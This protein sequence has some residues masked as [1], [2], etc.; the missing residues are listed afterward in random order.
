[1]HQAVAAEA[2]TAQPSAVRVHAAGKIFDNGGAAALDHVDL[3]IPAGSITV[4]LGPS[5]C[6]KTTLLRC[7]TGLETLSSGRIEI[8]DV[9]VSAVAAEDRGVAMVFQNYALYPN[10]TVLGN[11]EFPLKMR[12]VS[13]DIRRERALW[14]AKLMRLDELLERRPKELSGGQRQRVGIGRAL[15]RDPAVLVM[16]EPFSNL[17]AALRGTMRTELSALQRRLGMTVVFVTHD[18]VEALALADQLVVMRSGKVE[19]VGDPEDVYRRPATTFVAT[20]LGGMNLFASVGPLED[21]SR[22]HAAEIGFRPD[23]LRLGTGAPGDISLRG[24]VTAAELHGRDR[25]VDLDIAGQAARM[26]VSADVRPEG[27]LDLYIRREN[28]HHFAAD[29]N[30]LP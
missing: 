14:A 6:G 1:M 30:R 10:K 29:G 18:Q 28:L 7:I 25:L 16:D 5:G 8:G 4:L 17:D 11:I 13:K 9:D 15:V 12:R 26:R 2:P 21:P 20:F 22:P 3:T 27:E 19:Q 23:H 24:R